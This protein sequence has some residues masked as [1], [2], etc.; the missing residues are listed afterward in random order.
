M[1]ICTQLLP[2]GPKNFTINSFKPPSIVTSC[3]LSILIRMQ[4]R[5][6][7]IDTEKKTTGYVQ[8]APLWLVTLPTKARLINNLYQDFYKDTALWHPCPFASFLGM[9]RTFC[10]SQTRKPHT[11]LLLRCSNNGRHTKL[12][13]LVCWR[14]IIILITWK[15]T[16]LRPQR[17]MK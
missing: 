17:K 14:N 3:L 10:C 9:E 16:K 1:K 5:N 13:G 4:S 12:S 2:L 7:E 6:N 11:N 8:K 15:M